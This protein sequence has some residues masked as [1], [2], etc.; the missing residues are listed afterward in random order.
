MNAEPNLTFA[1][2]ALSA[3]EFITRL[4]GHIKFEF[5]LTAQRITYLA[6][7]ESFLFSAYALA[8]ANYDKN[9]EKADLLYRLIQVLPWIG[10]VL[11]VTVL[12]AV[13]CAICMILN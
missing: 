2:G 4:D 6:A 7:S 10:I 12:L 3:N 5:E 11:A 8:V 13:F 1:N 9:K